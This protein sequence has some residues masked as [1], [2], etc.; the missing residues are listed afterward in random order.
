[1][2]PA[3][4]SS[5]RKP[6]ILVCNDD[7]I[8]A[9]GLAALVASLRTI[10][11]VTVVAPDKQRSAV[12]HAITM[13]Y[14]LRV[15]KFHKEGRLFGYAVEGTPAD[16]VKLAIRSLMDSPPDL[17]VSGVN[18]GSNTAVNIIYS[19]TVSA[20]TEGTLLDVPSIAVSLTTYGNADFRPAARFARRLALHVLD[21]GLPA[22]TLLNVNVPAVPAS[23]IRGVKITRQGI[24]RWDDTFDERVDPNNNTYYWLTGKL[25]VLDTTDD[26]DVIAV[27]NNY[28]SVTP[29]QYDLTDYKSLK[30]FRTWKL[31]RS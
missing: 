27:R 7:G 23:R 1:M 28:I 16:C 29:I 17:L 31:P 30:A 4:R 22:G 3:D 5:R 15:R 14:P 20:A 11:T 9:P 10:S 12:G 18:H 8:D 24:S 25:D 6:S 26:T 2:T 21:T 19:G 13:N